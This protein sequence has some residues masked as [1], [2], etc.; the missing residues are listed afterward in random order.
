M[1][2]LIKNIFIAIP[3]GFFGVAMPSFVLKDGFMITMFSWIVLNQ[4]DICRLLTSKQ[5]GTK[6]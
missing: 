6:K 2:R 3:L 5:R 1:N 4:I